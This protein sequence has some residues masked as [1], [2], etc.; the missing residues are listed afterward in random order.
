LLF[1]FPGPDA[2]PELPVAHAHFV[3]VSV[4]AA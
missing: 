3:G 1:A 2:D 4:G